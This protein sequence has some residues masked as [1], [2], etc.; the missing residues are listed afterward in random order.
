MC[1]VNGHKEENSVV[2]ASDNE[3]LKLEF[4]FFLWMAIDIRCHSVVEKRE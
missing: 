4:T 2:E 1:S 3:A